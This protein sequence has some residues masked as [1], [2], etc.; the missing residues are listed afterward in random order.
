MPENVEVRSIDAGA[1]PLVLRRSIAKCP[2]PDRLD[3]IPAKP[4]AYGTLRSAI[5][6]VT[7]PLESR[8]SRTKPRRHLVDRARIGNNLTTYK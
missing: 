6:A 2:L 1:R 8:A 7:R 5:T 4:I 3:L